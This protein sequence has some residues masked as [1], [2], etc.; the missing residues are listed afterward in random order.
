[1]SGNLQV[2]DATVELSA[3]GDIWKDASFDNN[4]NLIVN[5]GGDDYLSFSAEVHDSNVVVNSGYGP[6]VNADG[7]SVVTVNGGSLGP[8]SATDASL[9]VSTAAISAPISSICPPDLLFD[10]KIQQGCKFWMGALGVTWGKWGCPACLRRKCRVVRL[11]AG[12]TAAQNPWWFPAAASFE[13]R[14]AKFRA[15]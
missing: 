4:A 8:T 5:G 9:V 12:V 15:R 14:G 11:A 1:M 6:Y 2:N 7:N 13:C 10:W 3:G